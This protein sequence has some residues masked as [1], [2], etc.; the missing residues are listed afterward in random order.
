MWFWNQASPRLQAFLLLTIRSPSAWSSMSSH[1]HPQKVQVAFFTMV[2]VMRRS[3]SGPS[4][5]PG[6]GGT[7]KVQPSSRPGKLPR[8][9]RGR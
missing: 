3:L 1:T 7:T 8:I 5:R 9:R 6:R 4:S 2:T